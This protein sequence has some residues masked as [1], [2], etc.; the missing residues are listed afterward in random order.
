MPALPT[1]V[2]AYLTKIKDSLSVGKDLGSNVKGPALN[3][4]RAQDMA[5]VLRLLQDALQTGNLTAVSG[6]TTTFV[7][8]AST[9][10]A[11]SQVGNI[12]VFD[13]ATPTTALQGLEVEIVA[14]DTTT[15]TFASP[16][17]AAV[18]TGDIIT[19]RGNLVQ[20]AIDDLVEGKGLAD[21]PAGS[22]YGEARLVADALTRLIAQ[23][24]GTVPQR[25]I[26]STTALAG[27]S[28]SEL[29]LDL[30]GSSL[31]IDA[32]KH[33]WLSYDGTDVVSITAST[34]AGVV[35][36]A[37]EVTNAP[38]GGE[39]AVVY[40]TDMDSSPSRYNRVHPGSH[41]DN[42]ILA[43]LIGVAEATVAAFVLPT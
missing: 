1:E 10:V 26:L 14:N 41:Q 4:L 11:G 5:S 16:L 9:F 38:S 7:D 34:A 29:A 23:L 21:S 32:L 17:P 6:S 3:Y 35:T 20:K 39:T 25:T 42:A 8:G 2:T 13:S 18:A 15:L 24:G 22:V 33:M 31:A 30:K 43:D 27:T 36:V 19:I 28:K 12:A 40:V 37:P